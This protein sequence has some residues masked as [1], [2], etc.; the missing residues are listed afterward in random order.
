MEELNDV[1]IFYQSGLLKSC[2]NCR[3]DKTISKMVLLPFFCIRQPLSFNDFLKKKFH[4][5]L[6]TKFSDIAYYYSPHP[7]R[8]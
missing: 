7:V 4:E 2:N 8:Q 6:I 3:F 5:L 1:T